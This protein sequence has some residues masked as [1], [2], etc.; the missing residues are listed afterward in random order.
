MTSFP[1]C[2]FYSS[3]PSKTVIE[4]NKRLRKA[5]E[6]NKTVNISNVV[7][8]RLFGPCS[9]RKQFFKQEDAIRYSL[10]DE[11]LSVFAWET[12]RGGQRKFL[13]CN[14]ELFWSFYSQLQ[15]RNF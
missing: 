11:D 5:E 12:S 1:T 15:V 2:K 6:A 4:R 13:V 8:P 7:A 14:S 9:L 3:T 10:L